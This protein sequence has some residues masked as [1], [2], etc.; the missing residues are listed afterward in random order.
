MSSESSYALLSTGQKMPL[1]GLGTWKSDAGQVS[2]LLDGGGN[3]EYCSYHSTSVSENTEILW[4][5]KKQVSD[6]PG[7]T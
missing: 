6:G 3:L 7:Q 4:L 2:S 5:G 1:V